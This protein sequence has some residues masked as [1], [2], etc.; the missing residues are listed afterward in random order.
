MDQKTVNRL[1][2]EIEQAGAGVVVSR[3]T[4]LLF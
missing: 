1:E 2:R 4:P 3:A